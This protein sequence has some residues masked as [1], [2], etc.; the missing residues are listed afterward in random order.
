ME[1]LIETVTLDSDESNELLFKVRIEGAEQSPA[2]VRLVCES[3]DVSLMFEGHRSDAGE[4]IVQFDLPMMKGKLPEG[5]YPARVEVLIEDRYFVPVKFNMHFKKTVTVVAEAV[6]L[7]PRVQKP[8]LTVTAAPIVQK[9]IVE[10]TPVT[11]QANNP[12]KSA[13]RK[14]IEE[15]RNIEDLDSQS[16]IREAREFVKGQRS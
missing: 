4:D 14:R 12:Q 11:T 6:K 9:R 16:I 7:A 2:K 15:K 3:N 5:T 8:T 1:T 10:S 13:L